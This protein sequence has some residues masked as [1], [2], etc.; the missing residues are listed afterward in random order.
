M[1]KPTPPDD[2]QRVYELAAELFGLMAAPLRLRI[3]SALCAGE[4][5]V[6]ALLAE[7]G[8]SQPNLS[9]HLATLHRAGILARR[10]AGNQV[11]YSVCNPK[12][13]SL[14]RAVCTQVAIE[15]EHPASVPPE[16]RLAPSQVARMARG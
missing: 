5:N 2:V 8:G 7:L 9:Q 13:V 16:Q 14:C 4:K 12:A 10:R 1:P 11:W 15:F 6:G 3:I